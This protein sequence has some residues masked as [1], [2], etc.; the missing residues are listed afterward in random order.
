M[1]Q[2][3]EQDSLNADPFSQKEKER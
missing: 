2:L 3:K 1:P